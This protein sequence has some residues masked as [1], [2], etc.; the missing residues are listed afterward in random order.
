MTNEQINDLRL[1]YLRLQATDALASLKQGRPDQALDTLDHALDLAATERQ[2]KD[3]ED[4]IRAMQEHLDQVV[5][6]KFDCM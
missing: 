6:A 2:G 5:S 4:A 3:L 1:T